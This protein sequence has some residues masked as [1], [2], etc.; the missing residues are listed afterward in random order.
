MANFAYLRVS[1]KDQTEEQQLSQIEAAGHLVEQD[2]V[3]RENGVSG[4]VPAL[5]REQF[6]RLSDRI[7]KGDSLIVSKI[8]RLGRDMLDVISTIKELTDRGVT[9]VVLGL[10][11]LDQTSQSQLTL[12][13][14]AAISQFERDLVSERTKAKLAQL[15][16]DGKRL[17]RPVKI[18]SAELRQRAEKL[19]AEGKSWRSVAK[20]LGVAL[21]TL[22]R[23]MKAGKGAG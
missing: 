7:G 22:Q 4:K 15:K 5:Q 8:D 19:F 16:A 1:T 13:I 9:V 20:S 2:R 21:S 18:E 10:G 11:K 3:Y 17:G 23:L 6:K 14:L 12:G